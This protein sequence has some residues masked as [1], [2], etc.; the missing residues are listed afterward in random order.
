MT[1][2]RT[3]DIVKTLQAFN[4]IR[5]F[6]GQVRARALPTSVRSAIQP[7]PQPPPAPSQPLALVQAATPLSRP[8]T[9]MN[10]PFPLPLQHSIYVSPKTLETYFT[11]AKP[12]WLIVP[13]GVSPNYKPYA[14]R[15][16]V[17]PTS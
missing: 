11:N 1:K 5:Y 9:R 3:D 12:N 16:K 17:K 10:L 13:D 4:L 7:L 8:L 14:E 15:A 2:F 6:G